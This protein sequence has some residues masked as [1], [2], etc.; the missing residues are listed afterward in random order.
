MSPVTGT[1]QL[2][3]SSS[4]PELSKYK[5]APTDTDKHMAIMETCPTGAVVQQFDPGS[6]SGYSRFPTLCPPSPSFPLSHPNLWL[7]FSF[8]RLYLGSK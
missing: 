8:Q 1:L 3:I 2:G 6:S 5:K 7:L 4:L